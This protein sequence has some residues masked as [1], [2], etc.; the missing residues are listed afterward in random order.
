MIWKCTKVCFRI[1][2]FLTI[3][4]EG[5]YCGGNVFLKLKVSLKK[6]ILNQKVNEMK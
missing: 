1:F 4:I 5:K 6:W 2:Y 3:N